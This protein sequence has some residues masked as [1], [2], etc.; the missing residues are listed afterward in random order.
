MKDIWKGYNIDALIQPSY[1]TPA[2]SHSNAESGMGLFFEY[3]GF[4]TLLHYPT[5]VVP[6]SFVTEEE[7]T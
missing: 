2:F 6:I 3:L 5:G 1:K 4:W 7:E